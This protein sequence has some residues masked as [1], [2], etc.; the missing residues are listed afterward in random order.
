MRKLQLP[1]ITISKIWKKCFAEVVDFGRQANLTIAKSEVFRKSKK[2]K[3]RGRLRQLYR[4]R[5]SSMVGET[6][7]K[8][9]FYEM[10]NQLSKEG[11]TP[12]KLYDEIRATAHPLDLCGYCRKG[13]VDSLDHY[14]PKSR[15][16]V[17]AITPANLVPACGHCNTKKSTKLPTSPS[18]QFIH[19]YFDDFDAERW[20]FAELIEET[21]P[22]ISYFVSPPESLGP[23]VAN[24]LHYH[25]DKLKLGKHYVGTACSALQDLGHELEFLEESGVSKI[26]EHIERRADAVERSKR[27]S[28]ET[29]LYYACAQSDWYCEGGFRKSSHDS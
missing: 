16:P 9:D 28:W 27:N 21:P 20:L 11:S 29:A 10:Y 18:T 2:Y 24:S 26:R 19:P 15:Y 1:T 3:A 17:F 14:L 5:P 22:S 23:E 12:R 6:A 4:F 25:F 13:A 7:T 8:E